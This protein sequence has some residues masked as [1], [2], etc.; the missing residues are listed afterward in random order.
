MWGEMR[1]YRMSRDIFSGTK[2]VTI[3]KFNHICKRDGRSNTIL[4]KSAVV[5]NPVY[6]SN[7][8]ER[9]N[10]LWIKIPKQIIFNASFSQCSIVR[11]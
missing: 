6:P 11:S 4:V 5:Q 1:Q 7:G 2:R 3:L 9:W 10:A 8:V